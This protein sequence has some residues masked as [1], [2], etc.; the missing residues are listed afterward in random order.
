MIESL[1]P[2][3]PNARDNAGTLCFVYVNPHHVAVM[4]P[5]FQFKLQTVDWPAVG[6]ESEKG[7]AREVTSEVEKHN[8]VTQRFSRAMY[9]TD[10]Q[11]RTCSSGNRPRCARSMSIVGPLCFLH[12][13][14]FFFA[15]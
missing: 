13:E 6:C 3:A 1:W 4:T 2:I 10:T 9:D 12:T 14:S 7:R 11:S 5:L 8:E 15:E